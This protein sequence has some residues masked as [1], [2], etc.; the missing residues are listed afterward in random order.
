MPNGCKCVGSDQTLPLGWKAWL[1]PANAWHF[2][3]VL[4]LF[5]LN[6]RYWSPQWGCPNIWLLMVG[7][8]LRPCLMAGNVMGSD[9]TLPLGWM[10][11]LVLIPGK[12][13]QLPVCFQYG[14]FPFLLHYGLL[15]TWYFHPSGPNFIDM[16][17]FKFMLRELNFYLC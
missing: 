7:Q 11:W 5:L 1:V 16:L 2:Y 10:A 8:L 6:S 3:H 15:I 13:G 4:F 17:W 14:N 12:F 9:Q